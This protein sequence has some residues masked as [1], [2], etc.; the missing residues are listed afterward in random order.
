[1]DA[2]FAFLC[3]RVSVAKPDLTDHPAIKHD[4]KSAAAFFGFPHVEQRVDLL[5]VV[6]IILNLLEQLHVCKD[7]R[8]EGEP[9]VQFAHPFPRHGLQ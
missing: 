4:R 8:V 6:R 5:L 7:V 3:D 1:M 9:A 2:E